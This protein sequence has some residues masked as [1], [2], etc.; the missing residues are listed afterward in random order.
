MLDAINIRSIAK[1]IES[2]AEEDL[3][4]FS[5]PIESNLRLSLNMSVL[6]IWWGTLRFLLK[7]NKNI[8][9]ACLVTVINCVH[10]RVYPSI[11]HTRVDPRITTDQGYWLPV[12]QCKGLLFSLI[13]VVPTALLGWWKITMRQSHV[14]YFVNKS[15]TLCMN[16]VQEGTFDPV[17]RPCKQ[18]MVC[19]IFQSQWICPG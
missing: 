7:G 2:E 9:K 5:D 17:I 3:I 12:F 14:V 16:C 6:W 11:N 1:W 18:L 19:F 10:N 13:K 15:L 8:K 4:A